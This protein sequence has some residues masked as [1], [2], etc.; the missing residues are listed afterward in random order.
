MSLEGNAVAERVLKGELV[1]IPR[2]DNTLTKEGQAAE[3]KATGA[4]LDEL[5]KDL[6]NAITTATSKVQTSLDA[7]KKDNNNPH[8]V[9]PAQIGAAPAGYGIGGHAKDITG[10]D[11]NTIT[12]GG[13]YFYDTAINSPTELYDWCYLEVIPSN[14]HS[15]TQKLQRMGSHVGC[16]VVRHKIDWD[17][18]AWS[19]W[20]WENPPMQENTEYR[21]TERYM[22]KAVYAVLI[23][24]GALPNNSS[25]NRETSY[26][27]KRIV[28]VNTWF[29]DG[30]TYSYSDSIL[31]K[32][33][34]AAVSN[35]HIRIDIS[36]GDDCS[37]TTGYFLIKYTKE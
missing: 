26:S 7:H 20:E 36:T 8:G 12:G 9:T 31:I 5:N 13:Y 21:T 11:L 34:R 19:E 14:G 23:N 16:V 30:E 15:V 3:A 17:A 28:S 6:N 27:A 32:F 24:Y 4:A 1:P 33:Y 37:N 10:Q 18:N 2:I 29:V 25:D 22:G 35:G